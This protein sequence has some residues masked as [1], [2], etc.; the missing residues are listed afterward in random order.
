MVAS[1]VLPPSSPRR[2]VHT[3]EGEHNSPIRRVA[4]TR[5]AERVR[6]T[7]A[8]ALLRPVEGDR[9]ADEGLEGLLVVRL[10]LVE[11]DGAAGVAAEAGVEQAGGVVQR[12]ALGERQLDEVLVALTG[13]DHPAVLPHRHAPP[14]PGLLDLGIDLVDQRTEVSERVAPPV[15]E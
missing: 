11:V 1:N 13:A 3:P 5:P 7:S 12:R 6:E 8:R 9:V 2:S 15:A 4:N 14:L 10:A